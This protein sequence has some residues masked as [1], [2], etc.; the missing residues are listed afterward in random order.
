M[1]KGLIILFIAVLFSSSRLHGQDQKRIDS[2]QLILAT[3]ND[4]EALYP[5]LDL[6]IEHLDKDNEKALELIEVLRQ[7]ALGA[8]DSLYIVKTLRIKGQVLYKLER[9]PEAVQCFEACLLIAKRQN[10]SRESV[11]AS[12]SFGVTYLYQGKLDKALKYFFKTLEEATDEKDSSYVSVSLGNIGITY[13]KLKDY[14]KALHFLT[15]SLKLATLINETFD[16]CDINISL[17]YSNLND[18]NNADIFLKMA[19]ERCAINCK[20]TVLMHLKYA[21]GFRHLR[22]KNYKEAEG[23][24]LKSFALSSEVGHSRLQLD[25]I[26]LIS[27]IYIKQKRFE[28]AILYLERGQSLIKPGFAFHLEMVKLYWRF[29][30]V[31]LATRNFEKA[32]R[33]QQKYIMLK[34]SI[35]S[36]SLTTNLMEV[37]ADY[38]ERENESKINAQNEIILLKQ[39]DIDRQ[40]VLNILTGAL[41]LVTLTFLFFLYRSYSKKNNLNIL[42]DRKVTER[43]NQLELS[44]SALLKQINEKDLL[45]S[46]TSH[47]IGKFTRSIAGLCI[48]AS[49][50]VLDPVAHL[51]IMKIRDSTQQVDEELKLLR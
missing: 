1:Q 28:N 24:L 32:A 8:A 20:K 31:Y 49:K 38:M 39:K 21:S 34:D 12:S 37:Q 27:E 41:A 26:F 18:F 16:H 15:R 17:C 2:L 11:M 13:Y 9:I 33:Y 29:S 25:N 40:F 6:V 47:S 19:A 44:R 51:Y 22:L 23:D 7:A 42:L 10:F 5:W 43:T 36:E 3:T 14:Q 48:T 46:R 4:E 30:E 50:E 45:I 35:Y